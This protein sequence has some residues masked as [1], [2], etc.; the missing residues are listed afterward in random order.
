MLSLTEKQLSQV[1]SLAVRASRRGQSFLPPSQGQTALNSNSVPMTTRATNNPSSNPNPDRSPTP[2]CATSQ[3]RGV[4][5]RTSMLVPYMLIQHAA[6]SRLAT[7]KNRQTPVVIGQR[8]FIQAPPPSSHN[9]SLRT[10]K[11]P[12][13]KQARVQ[14]STSQVYISWTSWVIQIKEKLRFHL[15]AP[16]KLR[17]IPPPSY[18]ITRYLPP[19]RT[20]LSSVRP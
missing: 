7:G 14:R 12:S 11:L 17:P 15:S 8:R 16:I 3:G 6:A 4:I 1:K 9:S 5:C 19:S 20:A 13:R 18:S 10:Y 2:S